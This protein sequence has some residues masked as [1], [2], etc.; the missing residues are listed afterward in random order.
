MT[1]RDRGNPVAAADLRL[2]DEEEFASAAANPV[3][4]QALKMMQRRPT[5]AAEVAEAV[6]EPLEEVS[7]HLAE[8]RQRGLIAVGG[9]C[10]VEG[11]SE[12]IYEGPFVPFLDREE[13]VELDPEDKRF[14]LIQVI[15]LMMS[16][17][18]EGLETGTL[19]AWPD[20]HL[21]RMP[22]WM[23]QQGWDELQALYA[24]ALLEGVRIKE[25]AAKRLQRGGEQGKRGSVAHWLFELPDAG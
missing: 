18:E 19:A 12:T 8:L 6:G 17:L 5:T 13:W 11:R 24:N 2:P 10:E 21:C 23:D 22:F 20:F 3:A 14:Q 15:R 9:A 16:D 4:A 1:L 7:R 25:E